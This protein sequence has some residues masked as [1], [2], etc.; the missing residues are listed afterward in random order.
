MTAALKIVFAGTPE[1]AAASLQA[2]LDGRHQVLAVY[3]QPD[4]PAGR[5]RQLLA[6][7]VK[8]LALRHGLP[9]C[10]PQ[11]LRQPE[12]QQQLRS[13]DADLMIVVAYGLLL[14]P[15][16]LQIPRLG[17]INVHAS[18]L[19]RWRGAAPIQRA[20]M[21]GDTETGITIMQM[22]QGLDTGPMLM[23]R[24]CPIH[25]DD[26]GGTLHDRLA[27]L[28]AELLLEVLE[29][30][31]T[32]EVAATPQ[33]QDRACYAAKLDKEEACIDW[34]RPAVEL[35]RMVRAF[36]PWPVAYTSLGQLRLRVWQAELCG[37]AKGAPGTVIGVGRAG[38]EVACGHGS[39]R[40]QQLQLPGGK[41][42]TA[43]DFLNA[44]ALQPGQVL[45]G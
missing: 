20:I 34:S 35:E 45:G 32:T 36:D 14:P 24:R 17:C 27:R 4:R 44:H 15:A 39:L 3:T 5:G 12:V 9:V 6:S 8:Q 23:S 28:G 31:A 37:G 41:R 30:V 11:G 19:P 42:I 25:G 18:L 26:T 43:R 2:V 10:Q 7:P 21:A 33:E 13:W 1:F 29:R 40:L 16:V 38:I 22:D